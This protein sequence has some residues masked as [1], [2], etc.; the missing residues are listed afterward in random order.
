LTLP[1]S[2]R[3]SKFL[4]RRCQEFRNSV[5]SLICYCRKLRIEVLSSFA[6]ME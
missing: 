2:L 4:A 6:A 3:K 1:R 5:K